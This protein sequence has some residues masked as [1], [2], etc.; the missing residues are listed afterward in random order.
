MGK[1][2]QQYILINR[3][4]DAL[5][6]HRHSVVVNVPANLQKLFTR[7]WMPIAFASVSAFIMYT[8]NRGMSYLRK[9]YFT[10]REDGGYITTKK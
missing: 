8:W 1:F 3:L 2:S 4:H 10:K 7:G 9:A 5:L 6:I